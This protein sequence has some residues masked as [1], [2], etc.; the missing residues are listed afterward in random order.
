MQINECF[1][2]PATPSGAMM[3]SVLDVSKEKGDK[4]RLK[5]PSIRTQ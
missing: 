3:D 2:L 5:E 1:F 4:F